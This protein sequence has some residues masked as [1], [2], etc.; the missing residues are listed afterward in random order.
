MRTQTAC[1]ES[2]LKLAVD[3]GLDAIAF[4]AV[5]T[6]VYGYPSTKA[7][8]TALKTVRKFLETEEGQKLDLVVFCNF[9]KKDR[10]AYIDLIP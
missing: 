2:A 6:G 5:S 8:R 10:D 3:D 1:Y 4:S 9:E 7:A